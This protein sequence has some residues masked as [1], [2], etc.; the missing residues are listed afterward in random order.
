M[1]RGAE[2][3]FGVEIFVESVVIGGMARESVRNCSLFGLF[4]RPDSLND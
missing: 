1:V 2:K 3:A 4:Y